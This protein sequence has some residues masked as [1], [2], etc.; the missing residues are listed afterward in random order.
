MTQDDCDRILLLTA[1]AKGQ[2]SVTQELVQRRGVTWMQRQVER[3]VSSCIEWRSKLTNGQSEWG[4][5][6][7]ATSH[8]QV[9]VLDC[10]F[11]AGFDLTETTQVFHPSAFTEQSQFE[12]FGLQAQSTLVHAAIHFGACD[13]LKYLLSLGELSVYLCAQRNAAGH[14]AADLCRRRRSILKE[15]MEAAA[16]AH[17]RAQAEIQLLMERWLR[18]E[19]RSAT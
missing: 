8:N 14:T 16:A 1:A 9:D 5:A 10:L 17:K 12:C 19:K 6:M 7:L 3:H 2:A 18:I 15:T 4:C 11:R 13:A